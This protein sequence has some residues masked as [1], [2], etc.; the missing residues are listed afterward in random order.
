LGAPVPLDPEGDAPGDS[1]EDQ[2][3]FGRPETPFPDPGPEEA[4]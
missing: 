3:A 1:T 2:H 4:R